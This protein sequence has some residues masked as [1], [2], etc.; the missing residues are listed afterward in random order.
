MQGG[1]CVTLSGR[2]VS[3]GETALAEFRDQFGAEQV[4]FVQCDVTKDDQLEEL[5][6]G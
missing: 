1:A 6:E 3:A 2:D 5:F 4:V